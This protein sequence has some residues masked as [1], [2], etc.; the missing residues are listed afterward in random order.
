[1]GNAEFLGRALDY[2][3]IRIVKT[4]PINPIATALLGAWPPRYTDLL[5]AAWGTA[6]NQ[7]TQKRRGF[8]LSLPTLFVLTT[9]SVFAWWVSYHL[10]W[11]QQRHTFI[12]QHPGC[13]PPGPLVSPVSGYLYQP[14]NAPW[15]L[16]LFGEAPRLFL[17][18]PDADVGR[19]RELFPESVVNWKFP[20][21]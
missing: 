19:A 3:V 21:E 10:N 12:A 9:W 17:S 16:G 20:G 7:T 6:M 4:S 8:T 13:Q 18:V 5:P 15:P 11:I 14:S 1:M 2:V